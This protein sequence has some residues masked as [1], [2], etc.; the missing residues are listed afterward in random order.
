MSDENG[1]PLHTHEQDDGTS[2]ASD[3]FSLAAIREL[4]SL[5]EDSD[6]NEILLER[7]GSKLQI[8]RGQAAPAALPAYAPMPF[9]AQQPMMAPAA[10]AAPAADAASTHA[11]HDHAGHEHAGHE[12]GHPLK[13]PMVGTFYAA[14]SPKDAPFVKEGDEIYTGDT[15]C[16]I[17]AMKIMNEIES[18]VD[19]RITRILVKD[20]QPVEYGQPLLL[21]EPL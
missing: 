11:G 3:V 6:V 12:H 14:S 5:I 10:P 15:V 9:P 8:K 16:I 2:S 17:E 19:G 21:I 1:T 4:V 7:D 13:A 18:D 20:G